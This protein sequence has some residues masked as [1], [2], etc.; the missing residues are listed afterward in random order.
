M[1]YILCS[2]RNIQYTMFCWCICISERSTACFEVQNSWL[3]HFHYLLCLCL[4]SGDISVLFC[5]QR[6][7]LS[8]WNMQSHM[9][10]HHCKPVFFLSLFPP[11]SSAFPTGLPKLLTT[12]AWVING[13]RAVCN[14]RDLFSSR[15]EGTVTSSAST[16]QYFTLITWS[17]LRDSRIQHAN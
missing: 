9:A 6:R 2:L 8:S 16:L 5:P 14:V 13:A 11:I 4:L 10:S 7:T 1:I 17:I 15:E 12:V 3:C